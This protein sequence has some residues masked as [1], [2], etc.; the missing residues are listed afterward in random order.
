[1]NLREG[2]A[3]DPL[4]EPAQATA[5]APASEFAFRNIFGESTRL[6][7]AIRLASRVAGHTGTTVLLQGETGTGKELFA[8]GIHYASQNAGEPFV[9][10]NC[11]AIPENLL[12]SEL[13]GHEQGAFTDAHQQKRGLLEQA[14]HGTVFLDEIGELPLALQPKLLRVLEEKR[15]RRLGGLEE[16]EIHC[17]VIAATN[18]ELSHSVE[19]GSFR[20]DLFYRL[21]VFRIEIP[22]LRER[23][24]DIELLARHLVDSVCHA[25]GLSPRTLAADAVELLYAHD[26]RGNVRELKNT[27]ERAVILCDGPTI[28]GEHI[29]IQQRSNVPAATLV[30]DVATTAGV[31]H[32]PR[33]GLK[34]EDAERLLLELT[35]QLTAN[36]HTQAARI[37]GISRP[38]LIRKVRKYGLKSS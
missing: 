29:V 23:G 8:R 7:S 6:R 24:R 22:P 19:S 31:I 9:P 35:L 15:V 34:L 18:R 21:S 37:L 25:H 32:V 12:E 1:M 14:G 13:F 17:R 16:H 11:A 27:I 30:T 4:A 36:N 10:I 38:T 3:T 33:T 2:A 20:E 28:T 26:W 5:H